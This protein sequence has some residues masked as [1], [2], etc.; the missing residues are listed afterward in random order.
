M[1]YGMASKGVT[2]GHSTTSGGSY[3]TITG[4][5][6]VQTPKIKAKITERTA[7]SDDNQL[8]GVAH[9][10]IGQLTIQARHNKTEIA[11]F[12][13]LIT[14]ATRLYWKITDSEGNTW[15]G[16]GWAAEVGEAYKLGDDVAV[17][18]MVEADGPWVYTPAA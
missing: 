17:D 11:A 9:N 5:M 1:S 6:D 10:E 18:M 13:G 8:K 4:V 15:G 14:A 7:L 16:Q 12:L 3:T 2:V